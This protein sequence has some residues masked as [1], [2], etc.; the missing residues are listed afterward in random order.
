[1]ISFYYIDLFV[2]ILLLEAIILVLCTLLFNHCTSIGIVSQDMIFVSIYCFKVLH[3]A[4]V[5]DLSLSLL[6]LLQ[7]HLVPIHHGGILFS[8]LFDLVG[9]L[10]MLLG[11]S[12]LLLQ[13]LLFVVQLAESIFKH[14]GLQLFLLHME[15]LLELARSLDTGCLIH[16]PSRVQVV[17]PDVSKAEVVASELL[18][19]NLFRSLKIH[20]MSVIMSIKSIYLRCEGTQIVQDPVLTA[21]NSCLLRRIQ[22]IV[23]FRASLLRV[24]YH[25]ASLAEFT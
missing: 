23:N 24:T 6:L 9:E 12:D 19:G 1:M 14:L 7:I 13:P 4:L 22:Y 18:G 2:L 11:N 21:C 20:N 8:P 5:V 3:S 17:Q 15:L 10:R 25:L 16:V